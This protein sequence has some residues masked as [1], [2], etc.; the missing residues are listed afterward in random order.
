MLEFERCLLE[1]NSNRS[2]W[3]WWRVCFDSCKL[4][5]YYQKNTWFSLRSERSSG[6]DPSYYLSY[7]NAWTN[8]WWLRCHRRWIGLYSPLNLSWVIRKNFRRDVETIPLTHLCSLRRW[9]RPWW[10]VW[11]WVSIP[12]LS[13]NPKLYFKRSRNLPLCWLKWTKIISPINL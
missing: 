9:V 11:I 8:P 10:R 5:H 13:L 3:R 4:C 12:A 6:V 7:S 2:W 1:A